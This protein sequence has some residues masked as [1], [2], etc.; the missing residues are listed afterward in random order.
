MLASFSKLWSHLTHESTKPNVPC[1][2]IQE[3]QLQSSHAPLDELTKSSTPA[4]NALPLESCPTL[5]KSNVAPSARS[6]TLSPS[7]LLVKDPTVT[8]N[9]QVAS[10]FNNDADDK[11]A[12]KISPDH[13]ELLG[14]GVESLGQSPYSFS[15]TATGRINKV[16]YSQSKTKIHVSNMSA[17]RAALQEQCP[18]TQGT[19]WQQ[20]FTAHGQDQLSAGEVMLP[21]QDPLSSGEHA[22]QLIHSLYTIGNEGYLRFDALSEGE[23]IRANQGEISTL[24]RQLDGS[25]LELNC[26][27]IPLIK[28]MVR[29]CSIVPAS[30]AHHHD[31]IGGL[32]RHNLEVANECLENYSN[33]AHS[34][35]TIAKTIASL[36]EQRE[37]KQKAEAC[38]LAKLHQQAQLENVVNVNLASFK[39]AMGLD[40]TKEDLSSPASTQDL[41][42]EMAALLTQTFN[43][44]SSSS[45]DDPSEAST[46]TVA[47]TK[48]APN[49]PANSLAS[50]KDAVSAMNIN[51]NS[52]Q[53]LSL[54][55]QTLY[56]A[57]GQGSLLFSS[58]VNQ[59]L[60]GLSSVSCL[61]Q[62][63]AFGLM[64]FIQDEQLDK[65]AQA[66]TKTPNLT[67][68]NACQ[69]TKSTQDTLRSPCKLGDP[70]ASAI[71]K[72]LMGATEP[73]EAFA[74]ELKHSNLSVF[75]NAFIN[76]I[77]EL[78]LGLGFANDYNSM[79]TMAKKDLFGALI[80]QIR[81]EAEANNQGRF[82]RY[83]LDLI[84]ELTIV[85]LAFAHDLGKLVTDLEIYND[86]GQRFNPYLETLTNFAEQT[87]TKYLYLR[88]IS[89]RGGGNYN[90][91]NSF[92][93]KNVYTGLHLLTTLCH[94]LQVLVYQI[95]NLDEILLEREHPLNQ[96]ISKV[97]R[98]TCLMVKNKA[99]VQFKSIF[100][101]MCVELIKSRLRAAALAQMQ[102][103][104]IHLLAAK[105]GLDLNL[106]GF[107]LN[108]DVTKAPVS[109]DY[110]TLWQPIDLPEDTNKNV[111]QPA[112]EGV[113]DSVLAFRRQMSCEHEL[114]H[115]QSAAQRPTL[116]QIT[117][118]TP[119]DSTA[120]R[121]HDL[122]SAQCFWANKI[123][124]IARQHL[125]VNELGSDMYVEGDTVLI[126][127][128]SRAWSTLNLCYQNYCY[129]FI[130]EQQQSN[131]ADFRQVLQLQKL[132]E[133]YS[134]FKE[135]SW[136]AI[137][138]GDD[139]VLLRGLD[140]K[141]PEL[142]LGADVAIVP[143]GTNN[144][145]I[146]ELTLDLANYILHNLRK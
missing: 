31:D 92:H 136:F 33:F 26:Y 114:D 3:E 34:K 143:L 1:N 98:F 79:T 80:K 30:L 60:E 41:A 12:S 93:Q 70:Y 141:F 120:R 25:T 129:G 21:T 134:Q 86:Q 97:D 105:Q 59:S 45:S 140:F 115:D 57:K 36:T 43:S 44:S 18:I 91:S 107:N 124:N 111:K 56:E 122:A 2:P 74:K 119:S 50:S 64:T 35:I 139:L 83:Q 109:Y 29:L 42:Q 17:Q 5:T 66:F 58:Q 13:N 87:Q 20:I 75:D 55:T 9:S 103:K 88:Y 61:Q 138:V 7:P 28:A 130:S 142:N 89:G 78:N 62:A 110:A 81:A 117:N 63:Q 126:E 96:L 23:L 73:A 39:A 71:G 77:T 32:I 68:L 116:Y 106:P 100:S 51:S 76:K 104:R 15:T 65:V 121:E 53:S 22:Y 108:T 4:I 137:A 27:L 48:D 85:L 10:T 37:A 40:P 38:Y 84:I 82:D 6:Q 125:S 94:E 127:Y 112:L 131:S 67:L 72:N 144:H 113:H 46:L 128:G 69:E 24:M 102:L 54:L 49:T 47:S 146:E 14:M 135:S 19:L 133:T 52:A 101:A 16:D 145:L 99:N 90:E 118:G 8:N 132:S 11:A 123:L 95:F